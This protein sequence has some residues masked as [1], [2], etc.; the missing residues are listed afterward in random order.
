MVCLPWFL[1]LFFFSVCFFSRRL[2]DSIND[3]DAAAAGE[4][5]DKMDGKA[6]SPFFHAYAC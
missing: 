4:N 1:P 5:A 3:G 6:L 2:E